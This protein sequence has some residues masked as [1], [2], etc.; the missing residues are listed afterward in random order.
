MINISNALYITAIPTLG[1][2]P[3]IGWQSIITTSNFSVTSETDDRPALNL[4]NPDTTA[5][6]ESDTP[7]TDGIIN[8]DIANSAMDPIDYI[9]IARHN[10]GTAGIQYV[11]QNSTDDVTYTDVTTARTPTDDRAIVEYFDQSTAEFWRLQ[12]DCPSTA[13]TIAHIKLGEALILQRPMYVGHKP[14]TLAEYCQSITNVSDTGQYLGQVVTRRWQRGACKQQN[15]APDWVRTYLVPFIQ[16]TKLSRDD[17]GT[18]QGP[19][20]YAWRPAAYPL[21]VIYGWVDGNIV[22]SNQR[23]NGMM[24]YEFAITGIN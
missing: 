1:N 17:D 2:R 15:T 14:E 18:P 12:L 22:P 6:W 21:E 11:L 4:W 19:F 5:L 7:P 20:F 10:F 23:P 13:P 24:E 8:I 9:G 3:I 16:H